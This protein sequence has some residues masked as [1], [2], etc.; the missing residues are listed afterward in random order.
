MFSGEEQAFVAW[1]YNQDLQQEQSIA[2]L[3]SACLSIS[4]LVQMLLNIPYPA[5]LRH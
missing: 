2:Q 1:E 3:T 4:F 5:N